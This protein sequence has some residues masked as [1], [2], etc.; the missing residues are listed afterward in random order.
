MRFQLLLQVKL[1]RRRLNFES[2]MRG[3]PHFPPPS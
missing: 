3:P 2:L 1:L